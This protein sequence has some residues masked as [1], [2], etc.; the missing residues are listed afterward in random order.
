MSLYSV[1]LDFL[2]VS[3]KIWMEGDELC[4]RSSVI[5]QILGL[6]SC[7][8]AVRVSPIQKMVEIRSRKFWLVFDTKTINFDE[9]NHID[10]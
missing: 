8:R 5:S 10:Y 9:I 4:G 1:S 6:F 2:S 3:P 7:Y